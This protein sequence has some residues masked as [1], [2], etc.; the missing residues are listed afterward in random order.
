MKRLLVVMFAGLLAACPAA[1][2][3]NN[4]DQQAAEQAMTADVQSS[5]RDFKRAGDG[6][7]AFAGVCTSQV[8]A[9]PPDADADGLPDVLTTITYVN[10][11][12]GTLNLSGTQVIIDNDTG[13]ANFDMST[14]WDVQLTGTQNGESVTYDYDAVLSASKNGSTFEIAGP[15][16]VLLSVAGKTIDDEHTFAASFTP[17]DGTWTP[18]PSIAL[19]NGTLSIDG[20][21]QNTVTEGGDSQV[22]G[23][24][25]TTTTTLTIDT[26]CNTSITSGEVRIL[27]S[28][29]PGYEGQ[30]LDVMWT[31]CGQT[32]SELNPLF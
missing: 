31:G 6:D 14:I 9:T 19:E 26:S 25:V 22:I 8:P 18:A 20:P 24:I 28:D 23:G 10:C 32:Q 2:P 21:W 3:P 16:D 4:L 12:E 5:A 11:V 29:P 17:A 7:A 15:S 27:L 30:F 13:N 1:E